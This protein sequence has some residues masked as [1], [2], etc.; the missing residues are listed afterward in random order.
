[1]SPSIKSRRSLLTSERQTDQAL[2]I[3][4]GEIDTLRL[5]KEVVAKENIQCD[6]VSCP[7][8]D[9][10]MDDTWAATLKDSYNKFERAGGAVQGVTDIIED[11]AEAQR[12]TRVP[13]ARA[14]GLFQA[15][16]M[17]PYKLVCG[18]LGVCIE[19]GLKVFTQTPVTGMEV[20]ADGTTLLKTS[21]G[22]I[23]ASKVVHCQK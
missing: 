7:T 8:V 17:W 22:H 2:K 1:M 20:G 4:A 23:K 19:R 9:V 3:I 18:L 6:F 12:I 5:T 10:A 21:K 16:S 14:A 13:A 15:A 11:P